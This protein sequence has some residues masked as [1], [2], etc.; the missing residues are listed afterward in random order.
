MFDTKTRHMDE[1]LARLARIIARPWDLPQPTKDPNPDADTPALP[2]PTQPHPASTAASIAP[3]PTDPARIDPTSADP[4][5]A[6]PTAVAHTPIYFAPPPLISAGLVP[7]DPGLARP[8]FVDLVPADPAAARFAAVDLAPTRPIPAGPALA[9]PVLTRPTLADPAPTGPASTH[10]TSADPI[11]AEATPT[12]PNPLDR[13]TSSTPAHTSPLLLP[14]LPLPHPDSKPD[15]AP[16][17]TTFATPSPSHLPTPRRPHPL[18]DLNHPTWRLTRLIRRWTHPHRSTQLAPSDIPS[19]SRTPHP[20]PPP[21]ADSRTPSPSDP[22][23]APHLRW[24]RKLPTKSR[25]W[26]PDDPRP[27]RLPIAAISASVIALAAVITFVALSGEPARELAPP[28]PSATPM[29]ESTTPSPNVVVDVAGKVARPGL[30]TLPDGSRVADA[31]AASGGALPGADTSSLNL[32]R[33]LVDGEQVHVGVPAP[34]PQ[35]PADPTKPAPVDLNTATP[36]Q[37]D[38]LPGVGEVTAQRIVAWRTDHGRFTRVDQ[39]RQVEGIGPTR[40]E[41]L[42]NLVTVR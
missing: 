4:A 41:K 39:L 23:S 35:S 40:Y 32:A 37:L 2:D 12:D 38:T 8:T 24:W 16:V 15:P 27:R 13:A 25:L 18:L 34:P 28:L 17:L 9:D 19:W 20:E 31:L 30:H 6:H 14:P 33:R 29:A 5:A 7:A 3:A 1:A 42:K 21:T 36:D 10:S 22:S 26:S 11:S